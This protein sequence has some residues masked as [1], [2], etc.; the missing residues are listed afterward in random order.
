MTTAPRL[1]PRA[2]LALLSLVIPIFN[3]RE[4]IPIL[5]EKLTQLVP[6]LEVPVE[7]V[8]VDDGSADGSFDLLAEWAA[9]QP[10]VKVVSLSRNF[11]H[12]LATTAGLAH[13]RG[14][15]VVILD[16]DLQDPPELIPEM[17]AG[18][19]EGYDVVYGQRL[20]REGETAFKRAT[21][22]LFY[23]LM[24]TFVTPDLPPDT[25][26]FRLMSRRVVDRL[27][28]FKERDRFLRGLVTWAGFPQK[29]LTYKRP[30]RAA[31]ETKY[32]L[33]KMLKFALDAVLSFSDLP[34]R[35]IIGLGML[36]VVASLGL[37]ART[38][39]LYYWGPV[40]LVPG[41]ASTNIIICFFSGT[42]LLAQGVIG[43]Y[44]GRIYVEA[45]QRP[46]YLVAET[47]NLSPG[48]RK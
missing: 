13:T 4:M 15:A 12:Q 42:I 33:V 24:R 47:I 39:Y 18:Y 27:V 1:R 30:A 41:W 10:E 2:N 14:E 32:P 19:R 31:G 38:F 37:I 17:I 23:F 29:A 22:K 40:A 25:G 3:E 28:E 11:G 21:A 45:K 43:M 34:L 26:D 46:L 20:A 35:M 16:A 8:L 44:V 36:S 6:K 5:R 9:A 48:D 7:V